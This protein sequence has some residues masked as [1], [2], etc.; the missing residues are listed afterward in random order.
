M[1]EGSG[2]GVAA[3]WLVFTK[4][5]ALRLISKM[6]AGVAVVFCA[7]GSAA[8]AQGDEGGTIGRRSWWLPENVFPAAEPIDTLFYFILWLTSAVCVAV[9]GALVYFLIKY[10]HRPGR[11][12]KFIHGNA[13]LEAAWTLIPTVILAL[14]AAASQTTW[15]RIKY[16][17]AIESGDEVIRVSVVARQFQWF[18]HYAGADGVLGKLHA[19]RVNPKSS[20]F[21]HMIGL[22]R[23]ED[24]ARDDI[25]SPKMYI[26]V[27]TRVDIDLYS[28]DVLHSFFLPNFRVKQDAVPG[29]T[30]HVWIEA[31]KTSADVMGTEPGGAPLPFEIVCAEL[32]GQGHYK[33][34]G[35]LF[36]VSRGEYEAFLEDE[37]SYLDLGDDEEEEY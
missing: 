9:F 27:N 24:G 23:S 10:R 14:T 5:R 6:L 1:R 29:L 17:P 16:R 12:A 35:Q 7:A 25:I 11:R 26:P 15:S 3:A 8:W 21:E 37:A 31:A 18:F 13:R 34:R 36:V 4:E 22:D 2:Y 32:C 20:E 33:M 19:D 28:V 30:G